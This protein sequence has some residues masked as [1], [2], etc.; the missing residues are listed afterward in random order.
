MESAQA[1]FLHNTATPT[2][3]RIPRCG[4]NPRATPLSISCY[5]RRYEALDSRK[6]LTT[7]PGDMLE[8]TAEHVLVMDSFLEDDTASRLRGVFNDRFSKPREGS[9]ERFV[10]D[11]WHVPDQY[12][13]VSEPKA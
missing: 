11:W 10:W 2:R 3:S 5:L 9:S 4:C 13:L 1:C 12:T 8:S 7:P 6:E